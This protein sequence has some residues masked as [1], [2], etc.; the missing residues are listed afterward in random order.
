M[1]W[2]IWV[3]VALVLA[4]AEMASLSFVCIM[5]AGGAVIGAVAAAVGL[6]LFVQVVAAAI[7]SLLLL[8]LVRKAALERFVPQSKAR[9]GVSGNI[10]RIGLV[11]ETVTEF[12]GRVK[13]PGD[14]VWSARLAGSGEPPSPPGE[15]VQVIRI[16]GATAIVARP[17]QEPHP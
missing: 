4:A 12:G 5:L 6:P 16:E 11:V 7:V 8:V 9:V 14:A 17:R 1:A 13:L 3:G 10:G 15:S 2:L